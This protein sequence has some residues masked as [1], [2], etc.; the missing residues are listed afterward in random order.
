MVLSAEIWKKI[1]RI[2]WG[3]E[4]FV[5]FTEEGRLRANVK[6]KCNTG[7]ERFGT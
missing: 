2:R 3:V 6:G 5:V 1:R 7:K 4:W